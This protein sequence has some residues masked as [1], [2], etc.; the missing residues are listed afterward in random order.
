[1]NGKLDVNVWA[2]GDVAALPLATRGGALGRVPH[3]AAAR[4]MAAHAVK[5]MLDPA[6]TPNLLLVPSLYMRAFE[7]G[8]R[9]VSW[10]L[11]GAADRRDLPSDA[12]FVAVGEMDP[13]LA[14]FWLWCGRVFA[15]FLEGGSPEENAVLP[16]I[17][18]ARPAASAAALRAA[19]SPSA[20]LSMLAES[21]AS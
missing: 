19:G 10:Q 13:K 11:H 5:S 3:V 15:V 16:R 2:V 17:A 4:A 20:A 9:P 8:A 1:M 21:L 14:G 18:A 7:G 12:E 6:G